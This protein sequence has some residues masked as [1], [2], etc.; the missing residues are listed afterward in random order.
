[1]TGVGDRLQCI[2][3]F[4]LKELNELFVILLVFITTQNMSCISIKQ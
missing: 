2:A 3:E 1:M 4:V